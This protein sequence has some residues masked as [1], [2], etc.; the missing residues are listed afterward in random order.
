MKTLTWQKPAQQNVAQELI[1]IIINYVAELRVYNL[2][3]RGEKMLYIPVNISFCEAV[4][5]VSSVNKI[6]VKKECAR[7]RGV[8]HTLPYTGF[9]PEGDENT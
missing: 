2:Y 7:I 4:Y 3:K 6:A 8:D 5:G 9:F 1:T